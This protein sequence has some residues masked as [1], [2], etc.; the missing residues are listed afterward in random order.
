[1][2]DWRRT[3]YSGEITP[4]MEGSE[5]VVAGWI[6]EV[7]DLGG[8]AFVVLRDREGKAQ[9]TIPKKKVP[10]ELAEKMTSLVRESVVMVRGNIQK[11]ERAPGNFELIPN[12]MKILSE[13][14]TPL[15]MDVSGKVNAELDTRLNSRYMDLRKPEINAIFKIRSVALT[16]VRNYLES[17]GY[18]EITTPKMVATATEGGTDLFPISYFEK[19]AFLNQSPQLFKQIMMASGLDKVY[20]IGPIFRAEE[21][22]TNRHLNES[23]SIDIESAFSDHNDVMKL[24]EEMIHHVT[25]NVEERCQSELRALEHN[26]IVPETPF[27]RI[28]Y[29]EAIDIAGDH[30]VE[31]VWGDDIPTA[32]EKAVGEEI[33]TYYYI[34]DWPSEIKPFYALPEPENQ[35]LSRAFDL[36]HPRFELSSGAQRVHKIKLLEKRMLNQDLDPEDFEFYLNAFRYGMPP[37][38]GWGVGAERLLMALTGKKN[39]REVTLFPRDRNRLTP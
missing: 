36:M 29:E 26:L 27:E 6:H 19:E 33:G 31:V 20:E 14:K 35:E 24:L 13:S 8:V 21:H 28:K 37:H 2:K 22:D 39:I 23:I 11:D 38:A 4:E 15:P 25:K 1:M 34:V 17:Q 12:D 10:E 18:I 16:E 5:V 32:G 9:I 30:G 3:H 7:R